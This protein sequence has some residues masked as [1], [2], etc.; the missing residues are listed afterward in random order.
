LENF[1]FIWKKQLAITKN[2]EILNEGE[3]NKRRIMEINRVCA[4]NLELKI[5]NE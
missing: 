1:H 4:K 2:S 5:K 3:E